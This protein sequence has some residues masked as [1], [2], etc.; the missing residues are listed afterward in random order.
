MAGPCEQIVSLIA[1]LLPPTFLFELLHYYAVEV[2]LLFCVF[3]IVVLWMLFTSA[4][5][6]V[7]SHCWFRYTVTTVINFSI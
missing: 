6:G 7:L 1:A 2:F 4:E 3:L 5:N